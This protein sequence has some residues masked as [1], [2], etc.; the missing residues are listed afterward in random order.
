MMGLIVG[1]ISSPEELI[2]DPSESQTTQNPGNLFKFAT[3]GFLRAC[4]RGGG[5]WRIIPLSKWL[6]TMV[7]K[8][9]K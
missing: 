7:S 5:T 1:S 6:I 3:V 8:S 9:T 4:S 2:F